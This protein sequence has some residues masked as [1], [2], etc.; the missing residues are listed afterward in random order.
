MD[1][2]V[3][4]LNC[5][6]PLEIIYNENKEE[7]IRRYHILNNKYIPYKIYV[8]NILRSDLDRDLHTH[9]WPFVS[10]ILN[11]GYVEENLQKKED[12]ELFSFTKEWTAPAVV[13]HSSKDAHR[14]QLTEP[15]WTLVF[16]GKKEIEWGFY[17]ADG[18]V[19][20]TDY[21]KGKYGGDFMM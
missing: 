9:P 19:H 13:R 7:Y 8:H 17:T 18:W 20:N 14:L 15:A 10:I 5:C 6:F 3:R 12:G 16:V 2:L 21:L 4:I 11:G 1:F